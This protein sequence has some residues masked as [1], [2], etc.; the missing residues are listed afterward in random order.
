M[1][2]LKGHIANQLQNWGYIGGAK[3]I[4]FGFSIIVHS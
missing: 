3:A 2:V 4:N 1:V